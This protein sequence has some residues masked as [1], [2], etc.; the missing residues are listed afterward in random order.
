MNRPRAPVALVILGSCAVGAPASAENHFL[1]EV[2]GG[3]S[4]PL[5][6][7][8]ETDFGPGLGLTLGVGGRL[9]GL[10]PAWYL[11]GRLGYAGAT[12]HGPARFGGAELDRSAW[13]LA[14]GGR[15]YLPLVQRLRLV[16]E[17]AYGQ[18]WETSTVTRPQHPTLEIEASP[19]VLIAFLGLQYRLTDHAALGAG[20][21]LGWY[22]TG[23]ETRDLGATAAGLPSG[24]DTRG[25]YRLVLTATAHF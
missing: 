2:G 19:S 22:L 15:M 9:K 14:A 13:E 17:L 3:L 1:A 24:D 11:V 4:A 12:A 21:D 8:G 5:A 10:T 25:R 23:S 20:A 6:G 7:E 18:V 16:T